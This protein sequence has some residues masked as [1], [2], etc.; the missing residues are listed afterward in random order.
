[1]TLSVTSNTSAPFKLAVSIP[2]AAHAL[3]ISPRTIRAWIK[4]KKLRAVHIGR[5][6]VIRVT[7]LERFLGDADEERSR[8]E[9]NLGKGRI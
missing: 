1:M 9:C 3:S 2:E 4:C 7:E 6:V 8:V 5:R